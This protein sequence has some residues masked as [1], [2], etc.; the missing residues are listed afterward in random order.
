MDTFMEAPLDGENKIQP[1]FDRSAPRFD[2]LCHGDMTLRA[3]EKH[4]GDGV[5]LPFYYYEIDVRDIPVGKI[6]IRIGDNFHSYYNGHIGYEID[7]AARGHG[8]AR[9]A[10]ELVLDVA[11]FHGMTRLYVTCDEDNA[12]SYR[13][14][15][16]LGGSLLE[17][18]DVPK[19]YFAW[20][21]GIK[22]H[23]IY[24]LDL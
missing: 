14:I 16:K 8:Y 3:I 17:I 15:E 4:P 18:C 10:C 12:A 19:E 9:R 7:E 21:E 22:R 2:R 24:R 13:T 23:R 1:E 5:L 11:R 6:S 20:H